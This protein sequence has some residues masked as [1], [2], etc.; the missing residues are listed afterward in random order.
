MPISEL[1]L[2]EDGN[3]YM[4]SI[5]YEGYFKAETTLYAISRAR[6]QYL[7]QNIPIFKFRH[8][9]FEALVSALHPEKVSPMSDSIVDLSKEEREK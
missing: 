9:L 3:K 1:E 6:I 4:N 5:H 8:T 7:G 2:S